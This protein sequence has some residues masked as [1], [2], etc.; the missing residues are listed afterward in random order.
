MA[1]MKAIVYV[2]KGVDGRA[3]RETVK[4]LR[5]LLHGWEVARIKREDLTPEHLD[6]AS[7]FVMPGG[8]D[9]FY[10]EALT[11]EKAGYVR[12]FVERGGSYLGICAGAYFACDSIEFEKGEKLE[13]C[14]ARDLKFFPGIARG[15]ALGTGEFT[16][17]GY[18]GARIAHIAHEK[19]SIPVYY[20]GGCTFIGDFS[21]ECTPFAWYEETQEPV[22]LLCRVGKGR[23]VLLGVHP[24]FSPE[25][26]QEEHVGKEGLEDLKSGYNETMAFF[27]ACLSLIGLAH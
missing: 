25:A 20:N 9:I 14:G 4:A 13:V 6:K 2:D 27:K 7:L 1:L 5:R 21:A 11:G 26:I 24:E 17:T 3:A 15:S 22:A 12:A 16:Y 10:H 8:R 23:A 18:G 19:K